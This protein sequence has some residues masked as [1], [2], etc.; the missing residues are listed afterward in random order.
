M[1]RDRVIVALSCLATGG[2]SGDLWASDCGQGRT[3]ADLVSALNAWE[4]A[5]QA[6]DVSDVQ[7]ADDEILAV[8]RCEVEKVDLS[9]SASLHLAHGMSRW[10]AGDSASAAAAFR[11]AATLMPEL[12][13]DPGLVPLGHPMRAAYDAAA[14]V[15]AR[16]PLPAW[17]SEQG[18][19]CVDG[20]L[21]YSVPQGRASVA[22]IVGADGAVSWSGYLTGGELPADAPLRRTPPDEDTGGQDGGQKRAG[23][24]GL[25]LLGGSGVAL[26]GAGALWAASYASEAAFE[27]RTQPRTVPQFEALE[28]ANHAEFF[29]AVGLGAVGAALLGVGLAVEIRW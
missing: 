11:A 7:R 13:L 19:L 26:L 21:S 5:W 10:V 8:L 22:Q 12:G 17:P 24:G 23:K 16:P 28:A 9:T 29:G 18:K 14:A 4:S 25:V 27:D 6:A 15:P 3:R 2:W 20:S 1:G